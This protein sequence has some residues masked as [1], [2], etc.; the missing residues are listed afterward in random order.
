MSETQ[1]HLSILHRVCQPF[2]TDINLDVYIQ[3]EDLSCEV[4]QIGHH[5]AIL[6]AC[7]T[8]EEP[9]YCAKF[10]MWDVVTQEQVAVGPLR[11]AN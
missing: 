7:Y 11:T 4:E 10:I 2:T 3:P 1:S 8:S 5:I 6:F 9:G